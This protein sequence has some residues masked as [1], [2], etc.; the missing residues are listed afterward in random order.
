[1][2]SLLFVCFKPLHRRTKQMPELA[3]R[4]I[5]KIT[6]RIIDRM[7]HYL[8]LY[9]G[10]DFAATH[11]VLIIFRGAEEP[12]ISFAA[13]PDGCVKYRFVNMHQGISAPV[14]VPS[15]PDAPDRVVP[16]DFLKDRPY[17]RIGMD[18]MMRID[19]PERSAKPFI[20][21]KLRPDLGFNALSCL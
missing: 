17:G 19:M 6:V 7:Y 8:F 9:T 3:G 4:Y 1:M 13:F 21:V 11:I 18:M 15:Q 14:H 16:Y 12:R 5:G 2:P 10:R 20:L